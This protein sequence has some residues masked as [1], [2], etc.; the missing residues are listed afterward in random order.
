M[1]TKKL[2]SNFK[3]W[4]FS[5]QNIYKQITHDSITLFSVLTVDF[6]ELFLPLQSFKINFGMCMII[7]LFKKSLN[8]SYAIYIENG[9]IRYN[10]KRFFTCQQI[11]Q[12]SFTLN[13][14]VS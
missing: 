8:Q 4:S 1:A 6:L 13:L 5:M 3:D 14:V 10:W 11:C 7:N 2:K 9:E 12:Y